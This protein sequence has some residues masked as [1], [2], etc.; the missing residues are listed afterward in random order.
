MLV[1][2]STFPDFLP[3]PVSQK[4]SGDLPSFYGSDSP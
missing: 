4:W 2:S 3:C 1:Y